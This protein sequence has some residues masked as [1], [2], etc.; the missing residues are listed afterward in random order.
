MAIAGTFVERCELVGGFQEDRLEACL[1][2]MRRAS[3]Q[4]VLV[5]MCDG[6]GVSRVKSIAAASFER[7]AREGVAYQSGV[8]SLDNGGDFVAGTGY[9]FELAGQCFLLVPDPASLVL[10]PWHPGT[11]LVMADPY[12][13]DGTPAEAAPRLVLQ[14]ALER[15]QARGLDIS[16]GF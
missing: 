16:W 15:L 11:A 10:T 5:S 4:Q 9:D 7:A 6:S 12:H 1:D 2:T 14:R 8:L 13:A 3:V